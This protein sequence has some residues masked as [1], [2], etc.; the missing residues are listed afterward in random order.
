MNRKIIVI[1]LMI[2]FLIA[3]V[4]LYGGERGDRRIMAGLDLFPSILAADRDISKKRGPDGKLLLILIYRDQKKKAKK[5]ARHLKSIERIRGIPIKIEI[6]SDILLE[7]YA[8]RT[9]AG[10]FFTE[11]A[12]ELES[13]VKYGSKH[14]IIIF[15]PFKGDV[16]RGATA[17]III[18]DRILPYVNTRIL[19]TA[20]IVL[21]PFFLRISKKYE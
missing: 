16:E 13:V 10:I 21:K 19:R 3:P 7:D 9:P 8:E 11:F 18:S 12:H 4:R 14:G 2:L 5:L 15:S 20:G 17:G 6:T 1:A